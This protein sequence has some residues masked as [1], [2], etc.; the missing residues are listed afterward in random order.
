MGFLKRSKADTSSGQVPEEVAAPLEDAGMEIP[1]GGPVVGDPVRVLRASWRR[2]WQAP[3]MAAAAVLLASGLAFGVLSRP[4]AR[5]DG[6]LDRA[7][8][9]IE[10]DKFQ[11]ALRVLNDPDRGVYPWLARPGAVGPVEQRRYHTLV[12]RAI[13]LGQDALGIE[14]DANDEAVIR[15]YQAAERVGAT[16]SPADIARLAH[17]YAGRGEADLALA[18]ARTIP[19][20]AHGLRDD[21]FRRVVDDWLGSDV[22]RF[23]RADDARRH[24]RPT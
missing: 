7:E 3:A 5:F 20:G 14:L 1:E 15:E 22:P 21:V 8:R 18:R 2:Q 19:D 4:K 23:D 17:A 13:S 11:D 10:R 16:L 6:V 24:L 9:L 12:A